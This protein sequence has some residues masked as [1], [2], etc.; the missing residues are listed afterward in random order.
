MN[1]L[2]KE[3]CDLLVKNRKTLSDSYKLDF[4][5][6]ILSA[7][8]LMTEEG[9]EVSEK[10]IKDYE[11][12]LKSHAGVFSDFRGNIR[13]PLVCKM[14][15]SDNADAYFERV[16]KVYKAIGRLKWASGS[17]KALAA[18]TICDHVEEMNY[19]KYVKRTMEIYGRMQEKHPWLTSEEDI[20][21]AAMLAVSDMNVDKLIDEMEAVYK[22]LKSKFVDNNA[23]QS[24]SHVLALGEENAE[25]KCSKLL[26]IFELLKES[27]HKFGTGY[28]LATLGTLAMMDIPEKDIAELIVE[29][30]DY[31]KTHK[32]FGDIVLGASARRMYAAQMVLYL[33]GPGNKKG[34]EA[35][36]LNG[37][38][39]M[40]IAAEVCLIIC[41]ASCVASSSAD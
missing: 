36:A 28:E 21:F 4:A 29:A 5:L 16:E 20:P 7:A 3:K 23:V 30:D 10:A 6:M 39:S 18:M 9:K 26:R 35:V 33:Y 12:I 17:Y 34:T 8:A 19:E 22:I 24:L 27:K 37:M 1:E 14:M 38:L 40:T 2:L 11:V 41:M 32:G 25:T 15:L 13:I 31:L